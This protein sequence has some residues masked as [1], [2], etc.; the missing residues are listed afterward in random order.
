VFGTDFETTLRGGF[1]TYSELETAA[2]TEG[3][4]TKPF[5]ARRVAARLDR[6]DGSP[7]W[8]VMQAL[9]DAIRVLLGARRLSIGNRPYRSGPISTPHRRPTPWCPARRQPRRS[10]HR[11]GA[12]RKFTAC[13]PSAHAGR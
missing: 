11:L 2:R 7:G 5:L 9:T 13:P 10:G 12:R 6:Q 4:D 1:L 3:I 8:N